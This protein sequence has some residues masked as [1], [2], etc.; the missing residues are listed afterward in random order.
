[1]AIQT[2]T[3]RQ[4]SILFSLLALAAFCTFEGRLQGQGGAT[5]PTG[6][7][8]HKVVLIS[9]DGFLARDFRE[10]ERLGIK[11]PNLREFRDGGTAT[12][13]MVGVFPSITYPSHTAMVTGQSPAVSGI[14][15]NTLFDPEQRMDGAEFWY[16]QMLRVPALWDVARAAGL[17]TGAVSWP[18][19]IGAPI[20]F[21]IPEHR[22]TWTEEEVML[23][24]IFASPGLMTEFEKRDG[25]LTPRDPD[26]ALR[27]RQAAFLL[28]E[29]RPDLLFVHLIDVDHAQHANGPDS[30]E[31]LRAIEKA[32]ECIGVL[33][34]TARAAGVDTGTVWVIVSDHGSL[35]YR[36]S[37][38]P[39]AVLVSI[40]LAGK[41]PSPANWRVAVHVTA[42]SFALVTKDPKDKEAQE[43]AL[44][45]FI[46]LKNEGCWGVDKVLDRAALD[47][48]KA[49]PHA[50]MAVSLASGY[51]TGK[52]TSGPW[53]TEQ[54]KPGGSHGQAPGPEGLESVF[55]AFGP[56]VPHAT[57][58]RGRLQDVAPTVAGIL[59]IRMP[60]S[61]EGRDILTTA[62]ERGQAN[63]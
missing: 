9:I 36:W 62:P 24:R 45:T 57:L 2:Q 42:G 35:P 53:L 32:D 27:T 58:P 39:G 11:I 13:G 43:I 6:P 63:R 47:E 7:A 37:L 60:S 4:I 46:R 61:I 48:M 28:Q 44:R 25:L 10:A 30:P 19:S 33:R 3:N 15:A 40:G 31:A 8:G 5:G 49:F 17:R 18:V 22:L 54:R 1:M 38:H 14:Y 52:N 16:A 29:H 59:G 20:D 26:D 21:N 41:D 51:A 50:F 55:L 56:S 23:Q 34:R 12:A